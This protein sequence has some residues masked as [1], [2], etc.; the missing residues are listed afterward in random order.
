MTLASDWFR[1]REYGSHM[2]GFNLVAETCLNDNNAGVTSFGTDEELY[3]HCAY[4]FIQRLGRR[5]FRRPLTE[6]ETAFFNSIYDDTATSY[7]ELGLG[8]LGRPL[9]GTGLR[10]IMATILLSPELSL[11]H[12][13]EPTRPY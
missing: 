8:Y 10:N 13:S 7:P 6:E 11:I 12:I 3:Q 1:E 2:R 9:S 4:D 5:A